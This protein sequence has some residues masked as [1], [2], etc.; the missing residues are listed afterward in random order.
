MQIVFDL[1]NEQTPGYLRRMKALMEFQEAQKKE[2]S[3]IVKFDNLCK[4]LSSYVVEPTDKDEAY[5]ALLE[6][7]KEQIDGL[8]ALIAGG[9]K[10]TVPPANGVS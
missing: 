5:D 1:P 8:F 3:E 6:A 2:S 4:Y 10:E 7:T 9:K